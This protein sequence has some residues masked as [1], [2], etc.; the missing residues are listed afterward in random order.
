[1]PI[2]RLMSLKGLTEGTRCTVIAGKN[3]CAAPYVCKCDS[4]GVNEDQSSSVCHGSY[5]CGGIFFHF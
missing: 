5:H 3:L 4:P 2:R 1:M